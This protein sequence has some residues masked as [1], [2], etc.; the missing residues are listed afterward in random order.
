MICHSNVNPIQAGEGGW[1]G[2]GT[3]LMKLSDLLNYIGHHL[4]NSFHS[5]VTK[6][7]GMATFLFRSA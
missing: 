7:N 6:G 3:R 5:T 4:K 1:V 2:D